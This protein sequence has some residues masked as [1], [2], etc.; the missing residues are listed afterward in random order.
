MKILFLI[1]A[2]EI[3]GTEKMVELL[4]GGLRSAGLD[5]EVVC[6]RG[7]G[8]FPE[9][10]SRTGIPTTVL[11]IRRHPGAFFRLV[12]I[13]RQ[14]KPDIL[15]SFLFAGNMAGRVAGACAGVS[16]RVSGQ[17]STDAWK[18]QWHWLLERLTSPLVSAWVSNSQAGR[19]VLVQRAGIPPERVVV[20][21]N[22][23]PPVPVPEVRRTGIV[24]GT[25]GNLRPAKGHT[26][27]LSAAAL[28]SKRF[29]ACRFCIV[30]EGPL[31]DDLDRHARALGIA[32]VLDMPGFISDPLTVLA[33]FDVFVLPSLWEGCPV[34]LLEAMMLRRPC[35]ASAVGDVPEILSQGADGVLVPA[36]DPHAL[37]EAICLLLSDPMLRERLGNNARKTAL[38]RYSASRMVEAH[39]RF[40][41]TLAAGSPPADVYRAAR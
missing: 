6:L 27:F 25:V 11:D 35:V 18:R 8:P 5:V 26:V 9:R 19:Q 22:G 20:I 15:Q 41:R 14:R 24:I 2:S 10:L 33:S 37:A 1:S 29:P 23:I 39:I 31:R 3:G 4:A 7:P 34:S 40:Y 12:R 36:G 38:H 13:L 17:R 30:G 32:D 28:I 16:V 21:P